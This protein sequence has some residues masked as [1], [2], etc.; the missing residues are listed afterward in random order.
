MPEFNK[1]NAKINGH[2]NI[3]INKW[4]YLTK[5]DEKALSNMYSE[6]PKK[7]TSS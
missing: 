5:T 3:K 7:V 4:G 6:E 1:M 2:N